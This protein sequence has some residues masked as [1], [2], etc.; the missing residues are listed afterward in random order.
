MLVGTRIFGIT[1]WLEKNWMVLALQL[2]QEFEAHTQQLAQA[3]LMLSLIHLIVV[4]KDL[5]RI[6]SGY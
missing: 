6:A 5:V 2:E 4:Y 3:C 1:S